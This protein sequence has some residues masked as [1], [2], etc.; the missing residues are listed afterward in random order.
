MSPKKI[1]PDNKI[2]DIE[3]RVKLTSKKLEGGKIRV[4]LAF[5]DNKSAP[6]N[7]SNYEMLLKERK[8]Q[9]NL[10]AYS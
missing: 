1:Y 9:L 3:Q 7:I 10:N 6:D 8:K 4:L 2:N 5:S